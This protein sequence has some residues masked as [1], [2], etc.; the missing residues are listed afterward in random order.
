MTE[1]TGEDRIDVAD[2]PE[3]GR[4]EI[5]DGGR[6]IG[7]ANYALVQGDSTHDNASTDRVVFFH[8]EVRPEYEGQ[9][10]AARLASFALDQTVS[11]GRT[12]V[13][14]CPYIKAYLSRHP[15]PYAAHVQRPTRADVQA[16]DR[17]AAHMAAT[18][19]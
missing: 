10:L 17:A 2:N 13:A 4:F 15:E 11:S 1:H 5:R 3:R 7:V 14:L 9:G 6:V 16:A 12:I 19:G 8:T 18:A